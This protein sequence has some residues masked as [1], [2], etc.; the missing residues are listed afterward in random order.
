MRHDVFSDERVGD[1]TQHTA[2]NQPFAQPDVVAA[3][4][5]NSTIGDDDHCAC[6]GQTDPRPFDHVELVFEDKSRQQ[7]DE[8]RVRG[9]N[10]GRPA[11]IDVFEPGQKQDVVGKYPGKLEY[12]ENEKG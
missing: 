8:H 6:H 2:G 12:F 7:A 4:I 3:Q 10:Q 11:G 5:A 9:D 1:P